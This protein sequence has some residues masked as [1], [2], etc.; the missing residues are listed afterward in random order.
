MSDPDPDIKIVRIRNTATYTT[1]N[2]MV[3]SPGLW[4]R[5][6]FNL[7]PVFQLKPD[8]DPS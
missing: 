6:D 5:I 8:P 7:D 3:F 1:E 2:N 4:I